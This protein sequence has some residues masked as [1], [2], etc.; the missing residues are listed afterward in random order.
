MIDFAGQGR[1]DVGIGES[2]VLG[3]VGQFVDESSG[4]LQA[5]CGFVVG[6]EGPVDQIDVG[7]LGE[8]H[9]LADCFLTP[10]RFDAD[11][12]PGR[13]DFHEGGGDILQRRAQQ[14]QFSLIGGRSRSQQREATDG[15]FPADI[16]KGWGSESRL[17]IRVVQV[18]FEYAHGC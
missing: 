12:V 15:S 10:D 14:L 6:S 4:Q 8:S 5:S 3:D 17:Q 2:P 13:P 1:L 11:E 18:D 16:F 7:A 9:S